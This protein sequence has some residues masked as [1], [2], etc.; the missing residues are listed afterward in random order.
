MHYMSKYNENCMA[1]LFTHTQHLPG[2]FFYFYVFLFFVFPSETKKCAGY[3]FSYGT[4]LKMT[5]NAQASP[6]TLRAPGSRRRAAH[7]TPL[8]G[9]AGGKPEV[10]GNVRRTSQFGGGGPLTIFSVSVWES[11]LL[12]D[13]SRSHVP[14]QNELITRGCF[15]TYPFPQYEYLNTHIGLSSAEHDQPAHAFVMHVPPIL[16]SLA[17]EPE[18][19]S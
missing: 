19:V 13:M 7:E 15:A 9:I 8:G 4:S 6:I 1:R 14:I 18:E 16:G 10:S 17:D 2:V 11:T 3:T 12:A 5:P